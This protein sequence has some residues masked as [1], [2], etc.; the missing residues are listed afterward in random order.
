[1]T[2]PVDLTKVRWL[3]LCDQADIAAIGSRLSGRA[4]D[5]LPIAAGRLTT[6]TPLPHVPADT[7]LLASFRWD[8]TAYGLA[9]PITRRILAPGLQAKAQLVR[10]LLTPPDPSRGAEA[11]P[12]PE[13]EQAEAPPAWARRA[14]IGG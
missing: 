4:V 14:D 1:M 6:V 10:L 12:V 3:A 9:Q 5:D 8:C 2:A 13:P 7:A 11:L